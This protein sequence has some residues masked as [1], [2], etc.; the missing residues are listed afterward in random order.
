MATIQNPILPG[1]NPD[2]SFCRVGGDYYIAT[3]TFE[4]FPGVQIHHPKDLVNWKLITRPLNTVKL[5]DMRGIDNSGGIWAPCLN[6]AD[7]KFWLVYTNVQSCRGFSWMS[8][9]NYVI[10]ADDIMGPWSDPV[11]LN[12]TGF[13]PS[14][15][16]DDDGR[17][18]IVN[19]VWDGRAGTNSFGGIIAQEYD[20]RTEKLVGEV[21]MIW[22]GSRL[23]CT[24]APFIL[25]KDAYYY[26]VT[27]EGGTN[28][29]HAVSVCR[30]RSI[31]G[32]YET[33][34]ENPVITS[35]F[36]EDAVIQRAGHG[37]FQETQNG[38][39][40]LTHLCGR[41]V[42]DPQGYQYGEKY[43]RGFSILG[44]ET[45]IQKIEWPEGE[46]PRLACGGNTPEEFVQAPNLPEHKW[47]EEN[48]RD[49]FS[50]D[51]NIHF[52]TLREPME[53]SWI[54]LK[55]NPGK[56]RIRGRQFFHS[57]FEQSMLMRRIQHH[58]CEAETC[59]EFNPTQ[60]Q[61]M[62][63]MLVYYNR[64]NFYFLHLTANDVGKRVIKISQ[65]IFGAYGESSPE[66]EIPDGA[67][68]MK[69]ALDV[70]FYQ[71]SY[72]MDGKNWTGIGPALNSTP[73]SDEMG[74]EV[75]RFTGSFVGMAA[76]DIT[77][78]KK[79]ADFDFFD[80]R[81]LETRDKTLGFGY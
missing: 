77:G 31:W 17:K 25:K 40:Y 72:S 76:I 35:R 4:W 50:G 33:H 22:P 27:A 14:I 73:L 58:S 11:Y 68:Y 7:G 74:N 13:D 79:H 51:L 44:R 8:T 38:E 48:L 30:S 29:S 37:F 56:L 75:F 3:S 61:E 6:Y 49:D 57:C 55:E 47:P 32:P 23:G 39:W 45:G 42:K 71:F 54:S 2:P 43:A 18:Y 28:W 21:K 9:P 36:A 24:E 78:A 20:P 12:S 34:P 63:G 16:H 52:Q 67:V 10:T 62:A 66:I 26:L 5:L 81:P 1:F 53:E 15:F 65:F 64:S 80:Y 59:L 41:P 70:Q 60:F 46:W 69:A 19:M